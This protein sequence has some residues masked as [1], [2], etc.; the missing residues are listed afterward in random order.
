MHVAIA[1]DDE[2]QSALLALWLA[3]A[4]HTSKQA[5]SVASLKQLLERE[6]FDAILVDWQ[7]PDGTGLDA[8]GWIRGNLGWEVPV[9]VV[10]VR[11]DE[12]TVCQGLQAGADDYIVKPPKPLELRARLANVARRVNLREMPVLRLGDY[13]A[14][15]SRQRLTVQGEAITLSQKEFDLAVYM[16]QNPGKLLSRDH[17]LNSIWGIHADV[18]TRTV[19]THVSR[20]RKKLQLNGQHGWQIVPVYGFGYRLDRQSEGS[21][22]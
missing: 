2:D 4:G 15:I 3:E 7:L 20:L 13:E 16:M 10:T 6:R 17:L 5:G 9:V 18:D 19:D 12:A 14:D 1:E 22:G 8:L 21:A 11:D